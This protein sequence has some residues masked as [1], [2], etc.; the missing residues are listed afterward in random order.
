M[1]AGSTGP[2]GH[3][4]AVAHFPVVTTCAQ[5]LEQITARNRK[6]LTAFRRELAKSGLSQQTVERHVGTLADFAQATLLG[7]DPPR[8]LLDLTRV[9]LELYLREHADPAVLTSF[10]R[11]AR[12]LL[13]TGR[14]NYEVGGSL[15]SA[16]GTA[17]Q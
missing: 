12:F 14:I 5:E 17:W 6:A 9:D 15:R 11:F 16:Q 4:A 13:N 2:I 8:G 3:A 10:K 7:Q 1:R